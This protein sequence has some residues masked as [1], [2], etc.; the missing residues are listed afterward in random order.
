[1]PLILALRRQRQA[2]LC[3]LKASLAYRT[4]TRIARDTQRDPVWKI[5]HHHHHNSLLLLLFIPHNP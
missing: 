1:M 5:C 3:E 2:D 4:S